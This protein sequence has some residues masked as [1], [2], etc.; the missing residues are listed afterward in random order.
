M[1]HARI[2]LALPPALWEMQE[3]VTT[4]KVW[5]ST[6]RPSVL[7]EHFTL[8]AGMLRLLLRSLQ[9]L[10]E[11]IIGDWHAVTGTHVVVVSKLA[12]LLLKSIFFSP[13]QPN[14]L[15]PKTLCTA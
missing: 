6:A 8:L 9:Q 13:P 2:G 12:L 10:H 5:G 11:C 3:P 1:R 4:P 7:S 14:N 15:Q